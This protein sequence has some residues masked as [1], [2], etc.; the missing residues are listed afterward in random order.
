[1]SSNENRVAFS[2]VTP[3]E[4]A[5][6][7]TTNLAGFITTEALQLFKDETEWFGI[8]NIGH[9]VKILDELMGGSVPSISI[10]ATVFTDGHGRRCNA[11]LIFIPRLLKPL[12]ILQIP[13]EVDILNEELELYF[14]EGKDG[15]Q[16]FAEMKQIEVFTNALTKQ[17][18][19][20]LT[21]RGNPLLQ[22][23]EFEDEYYS[24]IVNLDEIIGKGNYSVIEK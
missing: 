21:W 24:A 8:I 2:I 23:G 18:F 17:N 3:D 9:P 5:T 10:S 19:A 15:F 13:N 14:D 16:T 4:H 7:Y 12:Q 1:M 6:V 22:N 20:Y 11:E